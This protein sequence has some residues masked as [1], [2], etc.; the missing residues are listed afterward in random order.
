MTETATKWLASKNTAPDFPFDRTFLKLVCQPSLCTD[1]EQQPYY[2]KAQNKLLRLMVPWENQASILPDELHKWDPTEFPGYLEF[3]K[4]TAGQLSQ[5]SQLS[6][7]CSFHAA[8][9]FACSC[10]I[11]SPHARCNRFYPRAPPAKHALGL[12]ARHRGEQPRNAADDSRAWF[13]H[14]CVQ[15]LVSA[16][17]EF[18]GHVW[19]RLGD[20][21]PRPRRFCRRQLPPFRGGAGSLPRLPR[22][23]AAWGA[24]TWLADSTAPAEL[25]VSQAV[26]GG[27][28]GLPHE[29]RSLDHFC[30]PNVQFDMS[31]YHESID[32]GD[33]LPVEKHSRL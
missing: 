9:L 27:R 18:V 24:T 13:F 31:I 10:P 1:P 28:R 21:L 30:E 29:C 14:V 8:A 4:T 6:G 33:C 26:C 32:V 20:E 5:R 19:S 15:P 12:H 11:A 16:P 3:E 25:V 2:Q 22:H 7:N 23:A 17:G